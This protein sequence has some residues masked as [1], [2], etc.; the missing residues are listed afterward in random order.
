MDLEIADLARC[1]IS[2]SITMGSWLA[3]GPAAAAAQPE[4]HRD[5]DR[6]DKAGQRRRRALEDWQAG[7]AQQVDGV[8]GGRPAAGPVRATAWLRRGR[9]GVAVRGGPAWRGPVGDRR[10]RS[11][12]GRASVPVGRR[13]TGR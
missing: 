6:H 9:P 13:G 10:A 3:A 2:R 8:L 11:D 5:R 1:A 7:H 4:A 12:A